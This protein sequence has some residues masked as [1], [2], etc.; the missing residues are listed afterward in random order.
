MFG[1]PLPLTSPLDYI[2]G[3]VYMLSAVRAPLRRPVRLLMSWINQY[4]DIFLLYYRSISPLC[5]L[6]EDV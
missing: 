6:L 5:T 3:G 2:T 1:S 4:S